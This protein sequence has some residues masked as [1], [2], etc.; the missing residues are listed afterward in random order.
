[1]KKMRLDIEQL[2]VESF[3]TAGPARPRGTVRGHV[4]E[5]QLYPTCYLTECGQNTC[6]ETCGNSCHGTCGEAT[7][8]EATCGGATCITCEW[9][10]QNCGCTWNKY[11]C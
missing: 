11:P 7:C 4:P 3:G 5:T 10:C 2:A 6:A 1:M 9:T 8:G